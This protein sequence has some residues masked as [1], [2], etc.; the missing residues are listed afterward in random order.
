MT[1]RQAALKALAACRKSGAWPETF[2]NNIIEKEGMD[3][4]EAALASRIT[5][6]LLQNTTLLD[7]YIGHYC[8]TRPEKLEPKVLDI[9]RLTAYQL[10]F[11]TRIPAR[12]AVDE[13][14]KLCKQHSN[15]GAVRLVNAVLRR[16]AENKDSLPEPPRDDPAKYL[17]VKYSHPLWL[18]EEFIRILGEDGAEELL[19]GNNADVPVTVQVNTIKTDTDTVLSQLEGQSVKANRHPWLDG[20]IELD[21][22]GDIGS[23]KPF[24][25]GLIYVQDPAARLAVMAASP[26]PGQRVLDAC[27]APGGK[28]FAAAIAMENRGEICACDIHQKK[29]ALIERGAQRMGIDIIRTRVSDGRIFCDEMLNSFDIVIADVPCSGTGVIRKKP[30]IRLKTAEET[31][32]LPGIQKAILENVSRYVRPGGVLIYST[33]SILPREN[34]EVISE[35]LSKNDDFSLEELVLPNPIGNT[36][37]GML[38]LYPHIHDTDGFF[39]GKMRKSL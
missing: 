25:D 31:R 32:S 21:R 10:A 33:C 16:I 9:L 15:E 36:K 1:A 24:T 17:S 23:L 7:F 19:N 22:A 18:T 27:A 20:C 37:S 14:V 5:Y 29:L 39:I 26:K 3:S 2:L 28:T 34:G 35:F 8:T 13:G 11:L 38:T 12:A 6:G 4:R 30:E